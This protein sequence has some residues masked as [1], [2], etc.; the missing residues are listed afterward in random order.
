M[1]DASGATTYTY[2][3]RDRL[4]TKSTPLGTLTYT[5]D[6]AGNVLSI[7]SSNAGG[8]SMTYTYDPL[9][10]L[11]S[12][13]DVTGATTY[14][15]DAAG[16]L[17]GFAYPNGT[18]SAYAYDPLNRL[19]Q[20]QT[21]CAT[22][23]ACT[24]PGG[25]IARFNYTLG[26]AGNRLSV[27]ELSGR[28]VQYG[29]D[30]LYRVTSETVSGAASQNDAVSYQYDPVGNRLR[31]I[32]T[33]PAIPSGLLNYDAN[34]P[35]NTAFPPAFYS[36]LEEWAAS[37]KAVGELSLSFSLERGTGPLALRTQYSYYSGHWLVLL[38]VLLSDAR[39][40]SGVSSMH[41]TVPAPPGAE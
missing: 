40:K 19:T 27:A 17:A 7:A 31:L 2:D 15:Y 37:G 1:T 5:Y 4:L 39:W 38:W 23:P 24:V 30:D 33:L 35:A 13:T 25:P 28:I 32:S 29:Y 3:T 20:M 8:A 12:A 22:G 18:S 6:A 9:N 21:V 14:S 10:R 11:A 41:V 36:L 26:A 34:D 16:N